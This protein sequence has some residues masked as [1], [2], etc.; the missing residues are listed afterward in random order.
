MLLTNKEKVDMKNS[1]P[2][3]FEVA[4]GFRKRT[5]KTA[6]ISAQVGLA[7]LNNEL[8]PN[9]D[10]DYLERMIQLAEQM[11]DEVDGLKGVIMKIGQMTSYLGQL[12]PEV[13]RVLSRLQAKGAAIDFVIIEKI[14]KEELG[15]DYTN[16]FEL[17]DIE[18]CA[19]AS[20]GQVHKAVY[21]GENVAVKVQYP[22][23]EEAIK[24]DLGLISNILFMPL[25]TTNIDRKSVSKEFRSM[26]LQECDY[27]NERKSQE[28]FGRIFK[29][30]EQVVIPKIIPERCTKRVLTSEFLEGQDYYTMLDTAD[31]ETKNRYGL[32]MAGFVGYALYQYGIFN[33]DPHP[34]NYIFMENGTVGFLDFGSVKVF[35]KE[36]VELW[37]TMGRAIF[38]NDKKALKDATIS[39]GFTTA[40]NKKFDWDFNWD[41]MYAQFKPY[42]TD[43]FEYTKEYV[44][45]V[46]SLFTSNKNKY[47]TSFPPE[48]LFLMR[49][50]FG[51]TSILA[52]LNVRSN[53]KEILSILWSEP[54]KGIEDPTL[55]VGEFPD[56]KIFTN[57][58]T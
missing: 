34:G 11:V 8:N 57:K 14:I 43:D 38:D 37:K 30:T 20:I 13:Q 41:F 6:K 39:A 31:Q 7:M 25:A 9:K 48:W 51:F 12:P 21:K 2:T 29:E 35:K 42:L 53:W 54:F 10:E 33:A 45:E 24:S 49:F 40:D 1:K 58:S 46:S 52:D 15:D 44:K 28:L 4:R 18:P 55:S 32:A 36:T 50:Q 3:L 47:A 22:D 56:I 19:A 26:I 27:F 16:L 5:L 17:F 23:I